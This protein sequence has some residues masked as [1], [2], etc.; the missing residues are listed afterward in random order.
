MT[1]RFS[2]TEDYMEETRTELKMIKMSEIQSQ[3][4]GV[5]VVSI[6]SLWKADNYTRRSGRRKDN[7]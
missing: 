1:M 6:Y 3:E 4:S 7:A 2:E 5:A